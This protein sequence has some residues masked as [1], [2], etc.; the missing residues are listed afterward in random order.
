MKKFLTAFAAIA[1]GF[2]AQSAGAATPKI[3]QADATP[4]TTQEPSK[5]ENTKGKV[6]VRNEAGDQ[7]DFI[8]K[9]SEET[10]QMMAW[11]SSHASHASHAS[12]RSHYS[13]R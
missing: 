12:H 13:S 3:E 10:G 6:S 2:S 4:V 1:S 8:L 5:A 9:R 11:H 7:F